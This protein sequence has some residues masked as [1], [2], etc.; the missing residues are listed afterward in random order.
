MHGA[1]DVIDAIGTHAPG[2]PQLLPLDRVAPKAALLLFIGALGYLTVVPLV[3]LQVRALEHGGHAY[4]VAFR[5]PG[6]WT[7]VATTVELALGSLAIALVLGTG[8]AWAATTLSPRLRLLR[9][10]PILPIV[11]PAVASVLGWTFLFSP[12]PGY[13]NQLLRHLPWWSH[14]YNGPVDI[15]TVPWIII[16][17]GL[18]LTAFIYL[19]VS[20]GLENI[21]AELLEAAQVGGSS[22]LGVFFRVTLPLLR[23]ALVYGAGVGLLLGLGQFTGP[24]L[25]GRAHNINVLTTQM[26]FATQQIPPQY[27]IASALGSPLL[28]F[29][30]AVLVLNRFLLGDHSRFVTHAGRS[31]RSGARSSKLGTAAIVT[32]G[33]VATAL[34]IVGLVLVAV[35][36]FWTGSLHPSQFT[37]VNFHTI[38]D[39]PTIRKGIRTSVVTSA[40]A[41]AI[42]LPAGYIAASFLRRR[43]EHRIA[44][45]ILD[46][47]VAMPL[48][49]PAVIFGVGFLFTYTNEP[50]VLYGTKWVFILVYVTLMIPFST[51]MQLSGMVALGDT[52]A[53]ASRVAG[54]G[55]IRT[56]LTILAPLLRATF[57]GAVALMFILLANEFA[58]SLLVRSPTTQVMGTA[59]YDYFGNGL[60]PQVA[61]VALV[62]I[63][64]TGAGVL[65]AIAV[66]GSDIFNK[67]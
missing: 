14:Q 8:L 45:P 5:E 36:K 56:N 42:A 19:F 11:V 6:I 46:F 17:L 30:L 24:L 65:L 27:D 1:L 47:V 35:S 21:S 51:R 48:S 3:R 18:A 43:K 7:T 25:L 38:F 53:E 63:G 32:Y 57:G 59:L 66:G 64:V 2:R 12:H 58:A 9:I 20:A 16:I 60:Y 28:L 39:D 62:M 41:I 61:C 50:F 29:G 4:G 49:I 13:L 10:V 40:I 33:V 31:F 44:R 52:Y 26:F 22:Q 67:L 55:L 54:G 23:P 34:P 15:Y 37:L